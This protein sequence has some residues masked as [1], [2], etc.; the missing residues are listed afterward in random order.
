MNIV[1]C[2]IRLLI[3]LALLPGIHLF[4]QKEKNY[5]INKFFAGI[6]ITEEPVAWLEHIRN[7]RSLGIDSI[8]DNIIYSSIKKPFNNYL[9][10]DSSEIK[11]EFKYLY[12]DNSALNLPN[13]TLKTVRLTVNFP[14]ELTQEKNLRTLLKSISKLFRP[15]FLQFNESNSGFTARE[16]KFSRECDVFSHFYLSKHNGSYYFH[17]I[18]SCQKGLIEIPRGLLL[19]K[20]K[21]NE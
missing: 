16:Y 7:H 2:K 15:Y 20:E 3:I 1:F 6:P 12:K 21:K 10:D 4:S 19:F 14:G 18:C 5:S 9:F 8:N 13:D 11:I 17:V